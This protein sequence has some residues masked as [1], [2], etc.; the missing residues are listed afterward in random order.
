MSVI[1]TREVDEVFIKQL[2]IG[3]L[4]M[5]CRY[6]AVTGVR[7]CTPLSGMRDRNSIENTLNEDEKYET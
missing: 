6:Y 2:P 5:E 1:C 7:R 3:L 4:E